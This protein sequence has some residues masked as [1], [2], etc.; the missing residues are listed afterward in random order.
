[1]AATEADQNAWIQQRSTA[2]SDGV[3]GAGVVGLDIGD[4]ASRVG[5]RPLDLLREHGPEEL[6]A[7]CDECGG[8]TE[9]TGAAVSSRSSPF[10]DTS[11]AP[12]PTT[13][14]GVLTRD[15]DGDA[16]AGDGL[17]PVG[18]VTAAR[19]S[20]PDAD[21]SVPPGTDPREADP[22]IDGLTPPTIASRR[23]DP[24]GV[25]DNM[26]VLDRLGDPDGE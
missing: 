25:V 20:D 26:G 8:D 11:G 22:D 18:P 19:A 17:V 24:G 7:M 12:D 2:H 23:R 10:G 4:I 5:R 21:G 16:D 1:M 9:P 15:R 13:A 6:A 3:E 14:M